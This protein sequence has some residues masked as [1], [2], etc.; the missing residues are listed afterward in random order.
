MKALLQDGL[1]AHMPVPPEKRLLIN[2]S[3]DLPDAASLEHLHRE[4]IDTQVERGELSRRPHW[5]EA[6][7]V[8]GREFVAQAEKENTYRRR[9]T[10]YS[11]RDEGQ[12]SAWVLK[13]ASSSYSVDSEAK[14]TL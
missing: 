2:Q 5:T 14:S 12:P 3:L 8:G 4:G 10:Q 13:E 6:V 7:A 11:V 1:Q 9:F